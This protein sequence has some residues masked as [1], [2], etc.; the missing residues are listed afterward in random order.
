M[1]KLWENHFGRNNMKRDINLKT[2][3]LENDISN[4]EDY[5]TTKDLLDMGFKNSFIKKLKEYIQ[6]Y[7]YKQKL[8]I[9]KTDFE[10]LES[11]KNQ[12]G[13]INSLTIKF[14]CSKKHIFDLLKKNNIKILTRHEQP[15]YTFSTYY[16]YDY[17]KIENIILKDN[18]IDILDKN[19][20]VTLKEA[21]N[22]LNIDEIRTER[23]VAFNFK[24]KYKKEIYLKRDEVEYYKNIKETYIPVSN[25]IKDI[26]VKLDGI[27][28]TVRVQ[29]YKIIKRDSIDLI[30]KHPFKVGINLISKK[31]A[32]NIDKELTLYKKISLSKNGLEIYKTLIQDMDIPNELRNT[33][34]LY[35]QFV[36]SR[37]NVIKVR[38]GFMKYA[39]SFFKIRNL[40][41]KHLKIEIYK[42]SNNV[43]EK[44]LEHIVKQEGIH[45][46]IEKIEIVGFYNYLINNKVL[47]N[48]SKYKL[49]KGSFAPN[50]EVLAYTQEQ[51][52]ELFRLLHTK[53]QTKQY[54]HKLIKNRGFAQIWLYMYLH[55]IVIWRRSDIQK[56]L[57]PNL[58]N[59]GFSG[60]EF[61]KYLEEDN[62][63]TDEMGI[64]IVT[65]VKKKIDTYGIVATKNN[66][67]LVMEIGTFTIKNLGLLLS[68]C[69]AHR[70][71]SYIKNPN[72]NTSKHMISSGYIGNNQYYKDLFGEDLKN[73]IGEERFSNRKLN[74]S[75]NNYI[76]NFSEEKG[77]SC[78]SEIFAIM[79]GYSINKNKI[80]ETTKIYETRKVD[81]TINDA[82]TTLINRG[83]FAFEKF[84]V[85][86]MIDFNFVNKNNKEKD[87]L[88]NNLSLTPYELEYT[89]KNIYE[90][91]EKVSTMIS[92]MMINPENIN[93]IILEIANGNTYSK[94]GNS[95]CLLKAILNSMTI[96]CE[97]EYDMFKLEQGSNCIM[98]NFDGCIGC[99]FFIEEMYFLYELNDLIFEN[100][101]NLENCNSEYDKYMYTQLLFKNYI[102]ILKEAQNI[103]GKNIV[104][105]IV[106]IAEI[107]QKMYELR[108]SNFILLHYNDNEKKGEKNSD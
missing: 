64:K 48:C 22:I 49:S 11:W 105:N 51:F 14:D 67:N 40:L 1:K 2:I 20:Y 74:K 45:T 50:N 23:V 24:Q 54:L 57:S 91:R 95:R 5:Y 101:S 31:D 56:L 80:S 26:S 44:M 93:R 13:E 83:S 82:I 60:K 39:K 66:K 98:K 16:L 35:D 86:K 38:N 81:N 108:D 99:P 59:I 12:M 17:K 84:Q 106:N 92:T 72:S 21:A 27:E 55:Y 43:L 29:V 37:L 90:Q 88:I 52:V 62:E 7:K 33:I 104:N 100:I 32:E 96:D 73:I 19:K 78:A 71:I 47:K 41:I 107:K 94:H 70:E 10:K 36:I 76:Q 53:L 89:I 77:D 46:Q 68:I 25:F 18:P 63:F 97:I 58:N 3:I 61:L 6:F 69:E 34:E 65:D 28:D 15:F 102:P 87:V 42:Y 75:Y 8:Y 79:R 103:L 85:L 4:K 9:L 30:S